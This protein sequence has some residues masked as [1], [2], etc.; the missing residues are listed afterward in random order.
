MVTR[1]RVKDQLGIP[2]WVNAFDFF[3]LKCYVLDIIYET[4]ETFPV[5]ADT[6]R[7]LGF[8]EFS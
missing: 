3:I 2:G 1:L 7:P 6:L 8:E 4:G 5:P